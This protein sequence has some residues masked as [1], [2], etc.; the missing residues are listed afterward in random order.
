VSETINPGRP[1]VDRPATP[2]EI[3]AGRSVASEL[4]ERYN[5]RRTLIA[6]AEAGCITELRCATPYCFASERGRFD[7][8]A[9]PTGPWMPTLEHFPP[10]KRFDGKRK[11][12]NAVLAHR[13]CNNVGHKIEELR[14]HLEAF[15]LEDGTALR[16]EA[17]D[18]AIADNVEE[19]RTAEGRY[20]RTSGSHK[21]AVRIARQTHG[22]VELSAHMRAALTEADTAGQ[23]GE[24]PIGAVVVSAGRVVST[25]RSR[26]VERANPLAHAELEAL[27]AAAAGGFE[28]QAPMTLVTTVA[29]CLMCLG[30]ALRLGVTQ[31]VFALPNP[32]DGMAMLAQPP[33]SVGYVGGVLE[34]EAERL[35]ARYQA[36]LT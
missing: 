7:P 36:A 28:Q 12:T 9:E 18:A 23:A 25:G 32:R 31:I 14:E 8:H 2:Q 34:Q 29:P 10:A 21:R 6:A 5:V 24:L 3:E 1:C 33:A 22:S 17:I 27:V 13:R 30:A 20:P 4:K 11:V 35:F 19:R 15:R 26:T 16:S